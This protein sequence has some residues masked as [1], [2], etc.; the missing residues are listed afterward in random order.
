MLASTMRPGP[1][2]VVNA[3]RP[4]PRRTPG[5]ARHDQPVSSGRTVRAGPGRAGPYRSGLSQLQA[6]C[7]EPKDTR[8]I[9]TGGQHLVHVVVSLYIYI[10]IYIYNMYIYP[11]EPTWSVCVDMS[12]WLSAAARCSAGAARLSVPE[13]A[14]QYQG[15]GL[16]RLGGPQPARRADCRRTGVRGSYRARAARPTGLFLRPQCRPASTCHTRE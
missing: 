1:Q 4:G 2:A 3:P 16:G 10:Y 11:W 7:Q 13:P 6:V 12:R 15:P 8:T 14:V 9:P 5:L